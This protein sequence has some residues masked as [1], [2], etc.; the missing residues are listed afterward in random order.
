MSLYN[1]VNT[2]V[3]CDLTYLPRMHGLEL[4]PYI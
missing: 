2:I 4:A 1:S 3:S